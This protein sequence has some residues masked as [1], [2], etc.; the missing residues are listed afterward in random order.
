M[1]RCTHT[2]RRPAA[3]VP[4]VAIC[5][6]VL[7]AVVALSLDTG[8]IYDR[9][10]HCQAA[11]DAAALAAAADLFNTYTDSDYTN[12]GND[13]QQ[14]ARDHARAIAKANGYEDKVTADVDVRI[15]PTTG[16][17]VGK[18]GYVEVIITYKLQ[19]GFST[20]FGTGDINVGARAVARGKWEPANIGIIALDPTSPSSLKL[21]GGAQAM[22]PDASV[23]VNS[24]SSTAMYSSGTGNSITSEQFAI[25][26][27]Y[28]GG[29]VGQDFKGPIETGVPPTPDPYRFLPPPDK[30][31]MGVPK[32]FP[33][34]AQ[35]LDLGG[36]IRQYTLDPGVW[37]GGISVA[38]KDS[39]VLNEGIYYMDAGGFAFSGQGSLTAKGVMVYNDPN[40]N[41]QNVSITGQGAITWTPP[42]TGT[43]AGMTLFQRRDSTVTMSLSG[44]GNMN[45]S[46]VLY[47]QHA[48][49]DV[50]GNGN[51][52]V[53][54]QVVCW[55][56]NF[57]G[58]GVFTVP[59]DPGMLPSVRDLRLVE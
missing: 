21:G 45:I 2:A 37:S 53:G 30:T 52:F 6:P 34:D 17:F 59:W 39:L 28:G 4:T 12:N 11:A 54:N 26:G 56:M 14:V 33:R 16:L 44:N 48:L 43:Y 55:Q 47:S 31:T 24:T 3:V 42:L 58:N 18:K 57:Q 22:V 32:Q 35:V 15:P 51:N 5:L 36:G 9:Q 38:G 8:M 23:I 46:G 19:R 7:M 50:S 13:P 1:M 10:R 49:V 40:S 27:G 20:I 25:T 41:S 29:I